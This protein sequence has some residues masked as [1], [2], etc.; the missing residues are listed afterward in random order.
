MD[1]FPGPSFLA[2][3]SLE[4]LLHFQI[5]RQHSST[6]EQVSFH[7]GLKEGKLNK[8]SNCLTS[9]SILKFKIAKEKHADRMALAHYSVLGDA[10][11]L[12]E[13][14]FANLFKNSNK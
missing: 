11:V 1:A 6:N 12:G 7:M 14:L 5:E 8:Q 3:L 13:I 4:G 9:Y 2:A 10:V